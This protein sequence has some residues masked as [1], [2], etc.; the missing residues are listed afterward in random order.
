[1]SKI[2]E[3][4]RALLRIELICA[5]RKTLEDSGS[6]APEFTDDTCPAGIRDFDSM[7][8]P[9]AMDLLRNRIS[10]QIPAEVNIFL[11]KDKPHGKL[12][13]PEIV[14]RLV[15]IAERTAR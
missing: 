13:M 10:F 11:Q 2:S 8:W 4:E 9:Y 6:Q 7:T 12:K 5:I 15:E 1:M 3:E 14:D